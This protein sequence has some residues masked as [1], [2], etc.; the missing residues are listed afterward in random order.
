[1]NA[2]VLDALAELREALSGWR[3]VHQ[4]G[5]ADLDTIQQRYVR[6]ALTADVQP[7]LRDMAEQYRRATCVISRAGATT[8]AELACAGLPVLL[9]PLPT[10]AHDHQRLN[11]KLFADRG[12][13]LLVEQTAN[14]T[15]RLRDETRR[16][17]TDPTLRESMRAALSDLARPDA[18]SDVIEQLSVGIA[19]T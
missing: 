9:V 8:L 13:A 16:L 15:A 7:F 18:V 1:M 11:A 14:N 12:A 6:L 19:R 4:T 10:S 5:A 17:L 2:L 3:I